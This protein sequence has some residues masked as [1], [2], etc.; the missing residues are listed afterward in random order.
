VL[1]LTSLVAMHRIQSISSIAPR[2]LNLNLFG[3]WVDRRRQA[4]LE[5]AI[6][7]P[8]DGPAGEAKDG[9]KR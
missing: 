3:C 2:A 1:S 7:L 8:L 6:A 4:N 9:V 5:Q